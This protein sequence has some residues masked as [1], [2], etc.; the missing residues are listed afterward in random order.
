MLE[1]NNVILSQNNRVDNLYFEITNLGF[2]ILICRSMRKCTFVETSCGYV[3]RTYIE[4]MN[5]VYYHTFASTE[6]R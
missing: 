1:T 3:K 5:P 4:I 2:R 6:G